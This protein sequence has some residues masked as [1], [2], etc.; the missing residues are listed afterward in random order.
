MKDPVGELGVQSA[1]GA[2]CAMPSATAAST[3]SRAMNIYPISRRTK[4][5]G[6]LPKL[7]LGYTNPLW[8]PH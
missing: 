1:G 5:L 8:Y 6:S 7:P 2:T 3:T 4:R